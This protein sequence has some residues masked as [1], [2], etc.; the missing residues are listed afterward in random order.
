MYH[1]H[2]IKGL[3]DMQI[4]LAQLNDKNFMLSIEKDVDER[5]LTGFDQPDLYVVKATILAFKGEIQEAIKMAKFAVG[6]SP[7]SWG[8]YV[9][10]GALIGATGNWRES[11]RLYE[12]AAKNTKNVPGLNWNLS[13]CYLKDGQFEKGWDL[14]RY[15]KISESPTK[16]LLQEEW[17]KSKPVGNNTTLFIWCEQGLGDC[18]MNFRYIYDLKDWFGFK[19]IVLECPSPLY[20]LFVENMRDEIDEV[21]VHQPDFSTPFDFDEHCS[22]M[23]IP[24]NLGICSVRQHNGNKPYLKENDFYRAEWE[25]NMDKEGKQRIGICWAGNPTHKNDKNRSAKL[26]N[27]LPLAEC[28]TLY[29]F[30]LPTAEPQDSKGVD[31]KDVGPGLANGAITASCLACMDVIVTVDSFIA[32]L[33]GAL[34]LRVALILPFDCEWRWG[35]GE[36]A[37][38]LYPNVRMYKQETLQ[39]WDSVIS[40]VKRDLCLPHGQQPQT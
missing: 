18:V 32:H 16:R 37:S 24:Y 35:T 14:Y 13:M 29:S 26:E 23:D 10:L 38:Y 40:R 20:Q 28:G 25:K 6:L 2:P 3:N 27:F 12:F 33:A 5:L 39:D 22:I 34:G 11:M 8:Y 30:M 9:T 17:D 4:S 7:K 21:Y 1:L 31:I 36:G 19:K 15:R